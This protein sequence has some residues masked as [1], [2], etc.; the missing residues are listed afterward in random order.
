MAPRFGGG[1]NREGSAGITED[2]RGTSIERRGIS[3][4]FRT[5]GSDGT[6]S[7][8]GGSPGRSSGASEIGVV[9]MRLGGGGC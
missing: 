8:R 3:R 6:T 1:A 7:L 2:R 4:D 9:L 5:G